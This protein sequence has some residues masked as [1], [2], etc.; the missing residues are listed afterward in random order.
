LQGIHPLTTKAIKTL[1]G[2]KM[3]D[4]ILKDIHEAMR[5][6][7]KLSVGRSY[8]G[9]FRLKI[10]SGP[11]GLFQRR[12]NVTAEDLQRLHSSVRLRS[13]AA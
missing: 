2:A 1:M 9:R 7:A 8:Y 10:T 4:T 6:G 11:L 5:K 3:R 13:V 12:M